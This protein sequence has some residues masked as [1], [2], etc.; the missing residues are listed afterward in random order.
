MKTLLREK[1]LIYTDAEAMRVVTNDRFIAEQIKS[2]KVEN[3]MV[4]GSKVGQLRKIERQQNSK[5]VVMDQKVGEFGKVGREQ[6]IDEHRDG[7]I[8]L[9]K[10]IS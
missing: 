9:E 10:R 2:D 6:K 1:Q 5:S 7:R 4:D 3:V 8:Q